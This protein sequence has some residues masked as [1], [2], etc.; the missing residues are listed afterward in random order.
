MKKFIFAL[1]GITLTTMT[2]MAAVSATMDDERAI[3]YKDLPAEARSFI[4]KHFANEE[5]SYATVDRDLA[6]TEYKVVMASGMEIDFDG[7]GE[8]MEVDCRYTSVPDEIVPQKIL[9]Y[10][11]RHYPQS[12][13]VE[14]SKESRGWDIKLSGGLEL[15]FDNM[16]RLAEIDN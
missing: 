12:K 13:I 15:S 5:P 9:D 8:W 6:Y 4:A 3:K 1:M 7:K 2:A 11:K 14:I 16:Y 10:V